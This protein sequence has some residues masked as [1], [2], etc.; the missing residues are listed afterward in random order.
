MMELMTLSIAAFACCLSLLR[1]L[2]YGCARIM[3]IVLVACVR[4][5]VRSK[6]TTMCF[7]PYIKF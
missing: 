2:G 6:C 7:K 3:G 1:Q 5:N 4:G